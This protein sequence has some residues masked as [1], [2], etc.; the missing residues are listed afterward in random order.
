MFDVSII[1]LEIKPHDNSGSATTGR[2]V[3]QYGRGKVF[4]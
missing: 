2:S 3:D 1:I 4:Q